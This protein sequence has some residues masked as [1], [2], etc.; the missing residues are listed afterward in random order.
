MTDQLPFYESVRDFMDHFMARSMRDWKRFARDAGLTMPQFFTMMQVHQHGFC[1]ISHIAGRFETTSAA[2][3]QLA[4]KL[5]Q[6][7]LLER[8]EDPDDRRS[9]R[10]TLTPKGLRLVEQSF[11]ERYRW[12]EE[13]AA[14]LNADE[15]QRILE[16]LDT[17]IAAA[18]KPETQT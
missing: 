10:L 3:S 9:R 11:H 6:A 2:A 13:L 8:T 16:V 15:Q 5:V 1:N 4:E 18:P 7:G 17:M 14:R 12:V